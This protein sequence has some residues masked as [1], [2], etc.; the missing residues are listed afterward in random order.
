[1]DVLIDGNQRFTKSISLHRDFLDI[2][3]ITKNQQHP[4]AAILG[5]SDSR[6]AT[7]II[8]DQGLGDIFSVRLAGNIASQFAIGSLEFSCKYLGSKLIVVL[9]HSNCGAV[10][11]ACDHFTG[12][13]IG[14]IL[15][16]IEP[17]VKHEQA[18]AGSL[19]SSDLA[20]VDRVGHSNVAFQIQTILDKSEILRNML[21]TKQIGIA[22]AMY[23]VSSG[24]VTFD[25]SQ[26]LF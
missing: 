20:F 2:V 15:K 14:E 26:S 7:E 17:A 4:F 12:G 1:M 6:T 8:F 19:D 25:H 23:D 3:D 24:L 11:A 18:I 13:Y 9:G 22:A 10:K 5:C 16:H 21:E